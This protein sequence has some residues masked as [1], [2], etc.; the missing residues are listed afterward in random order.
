MIERNK[1]PRRTDAGRPTNGCIRRGLI[2]IKLTAGKTRQIWSEEANL[3]AQDERCR[4]LPLFNTMRLETF[5]RVMARARRQSFPPGAML[6][7]EGKATDLLYVLLA[8]QV[9]LNGAWRSRESVL[10]I[11]GPGAA[12]ML[13][14]ATL[15]TPA[16]MSARTLEASE[17]L[18]LEAKTIREAISADAAFAASVARDIARAHEAVVASLKAQKLRSSVERL[19]QYL[20]TLRDTENACAGSLVL[21]HE[22]RVL[23][24]LLGMTP[25]NLSR[26]FAALRAHGVIVQGAVV[27]LSD[28]AALRALANP[29]LLTETPARP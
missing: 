13:A 3:A 12:L 5:R 10:A 20:V 22:K 16:L 1:S 27:T 23:A 24:S 4:S 18:M 15:G 11:E 21:R 25:E 14:A 7:Y 8:G 17:L 29:D 19:A 26:A 6:M 9:E 2:R 28:P